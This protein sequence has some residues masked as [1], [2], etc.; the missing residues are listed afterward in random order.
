MSLVIL[1]Q[2]AVPDKKW[3]GLF[4]TAIENRLAV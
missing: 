4:A 2:I 3:V 1:G